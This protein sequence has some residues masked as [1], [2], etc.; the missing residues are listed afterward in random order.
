MYMRRTY[1]KFVN[2]QVLNIV[3][4][5]W[6]TPWK[7]Y[8]SSTVF[9]MSSGSGKCGVAVIRV[10]GPR[11]RQSLEQLCGGVTL[12]RVASLQK[13]I[14]PTSKEMLDKAIVLWFPGKSPYSE[15]RFELF[16]ILVILH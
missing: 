9:S 4:S 16:K 5:L 3:K 6:K 2:G 10:S 8:A 11:S 15:D 14:H 12:P 7:R 13:L 1:E